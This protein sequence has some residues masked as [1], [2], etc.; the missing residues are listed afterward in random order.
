MTQVTNTTELLATAVEAAQAGDFMTLEEL[1]GVLEGWM[2][3]ESER[4]LCSRT[5]NNLMAMV[6]EMA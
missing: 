6:E 4:E 1:Q 5:L 2:V 3:D